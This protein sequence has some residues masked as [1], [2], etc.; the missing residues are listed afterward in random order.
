MKK[1]SS[2]TITLLA[3]SLWTLFSGCES[4]LDLPVDNFSKLTII[5][6]LATGSWEKQRVYVHASLS[7]SDSSQFYTPA[8]L[9]VDVIEKETDIIIRLDSI[10]KGNEVYFDFPSGFLKAGNSYSISAS[11]PGFETVR[12]ETVIPE[13]STIS[14]LAIND[15]D[16]QPSEK[17]EFKEIIRYKVVFNINHV[18]SNRYYHLVFYNKYSG[19]AGLLM[20][21]PELSDD[22][23]YLKHYA[24]G[25]LL[26]KDDLKNPD[27]PLSFNFVDWIVEDDALE[28][29]YVELR[30]ITEEYYRYHSTLAR[31]LLAREDPFAEPVSIYNNIEGGYGN[32]SGFSPGVYSSD[33]PK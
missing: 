21:D 23:L 24:Y 4:S 7:P 27:Q 6:H 33:L 1:R 29:V 9:E 25:L 28:R 18:G 20:V 3:L 11:A 14:N 13:P 12:A 32:F 2:G 16:I 5:S 10:R 31:Q 17:N 26:D 8:G 15:L 19:F 30:S 22:Q